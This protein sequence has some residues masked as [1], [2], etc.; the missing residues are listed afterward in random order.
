MAS[1]NQNRYPILLPD[2]R[3]LGVML[4]ILLVATAM[5][6]AAAAVQASNWNM[7]VDHWLEI[8]ALVQPIVILSLVVLALATGWLHRLEYPAAVAIVI[9]IELVIASA[10][11]S[12]TASLFESA[13]S[14]V[15]R[16]MLFTL[17]ATAVLLGYFNLRNRALSPAITE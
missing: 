6:L 15:V 13:A 3:N 8:S 14:D 11:V 17:A 1:I 9:L 7:L 5:T 10:A 2:F 16:A 4:R 12:F